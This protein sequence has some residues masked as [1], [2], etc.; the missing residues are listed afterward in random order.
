MQTGH[1]GVDS[2]AA[3]VKCS[4]QVLPIH[5]SLH[6]FILLSISNEMTLR[7]ASKN[8]HLSIIFRYRLDTMLT[9]NYI[10]FL[11]D[12]KSTIEYIML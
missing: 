12:R 4:G 8:W 3:L 2:S 6:K 10:D 1:L 11:W 7:K 5:T 9:N